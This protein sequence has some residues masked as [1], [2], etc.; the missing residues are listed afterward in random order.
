M[1]DSNALFLL[2]LSCS[3]NANRLDALVVSPARPNCGTRGPPTNFPQGGVGVPRGAA[4]VES[5]CS[6]A[7]MHPVQGKGVIL[8]IVSLI[9]GQEN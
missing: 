9:H 3:D 8:V 1:R 4:N 7:A 2:S 6:S 5:S